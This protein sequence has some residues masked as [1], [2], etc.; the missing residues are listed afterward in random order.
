MLSFVKLR[1]FLKK[2]FGALNEEDIIHAHGERFKADCK[3]ILRIIESKNKEVERMHRDIEH[4]HKVIN[5]QKWRDALDVS[6]RLN[7]EI[8]NLQDIVE[9]EIED[10][11]EP[12]NLQSVRTIEKTREDM[13][14]R[15]NKV[16]L[17]ISKLENSTLEHK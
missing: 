2:M 4:N 3:K 8:M 15:L 11:I 16:K 17:L 6:A 14:S 13:I 12:I 10:Y 5:T 7:I 1:L 9:R